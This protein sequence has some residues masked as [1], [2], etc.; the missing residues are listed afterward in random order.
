MMG[1]DSH[2]YLGSAEALRAG[3]PIDER[4]ENYVGFVLYLALIGWLAPDRDALAWAAVV[5]QSGVSLLA[6]LCVYGIGRTVLSGT[7]GALASLFY[8]A[9]PYAMVWNRYLLTDSLFI[10]FVL[11]SLW[12]LI[13]TSRRRAWLTLALPAC[14]FTALLRPNGLFYTPVFLVYLLFLLGRRARLAAG[15]L[16]AVALLAGLPFIASEVQKATDRIQ[17]ID[18]LAAGVTIWRTARIDMPEYRSPRT[19]PIA[20]FAAY[21][22][23]YPAETLRLLAARLRV[24]YLF[25]RDDF[26]PRHNALLRVTLPTLYGFAVAGMVRRLAAAARRDALLLVGVLAV[27]TAILALTYSDHDPRFTCYTLTLVALFAAHGL[28]G[29]PGAVRR[30]SPPT[31]HGTAGPDPMARVRDSGSPGP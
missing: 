17:V 28:D 31:L 9:N 4:D 20:D 14:A 2:R 13:R 8:A 11:I 25:T 21:A 23:A 29:L 18:H 12:A 27:Q 10:S 16:F 15:A 3:K 30:P 6:L 7:S 5:V 26:S 22:T 24:A 19:H 1:G